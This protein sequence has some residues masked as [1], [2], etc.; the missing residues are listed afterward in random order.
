LSG[1]HRTRPG[2]WPGATSI[3]TSRAAARAA[4]CSTAEPDRARLEVAAVGAAQ[5][6]QQAALGQGGEGGVAAGADL[7]HDLAGALRDLA[8]VP[9]EDDADVGLDRR[10]RR[11]DLVRGLPQVAGLVGVRAVD[12]GGEL[13]QQAH[14]EVGTGGAQQAVAGEPARPQGGEGGG[15]A[16]R[17]DDQVEVAVGGELVE[18]VGGAAG[19]AV[20]TSERETRGVGIAVDHV[21]DL[22]SRH[23]QE[24]REDRRAALSRADERDDVSVLSHVVFSCRAPHGCGKWSRESDTVNGGR[25]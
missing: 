6:G 8:G 19:D 9:A 17:L 13:G 3:A 25:S 1:S 16:A 15:V 23:A 4:S 7:L 20:L 14:D 21:A 11:F 18:A 24:R 12:D 10:E 5:V 2:P 22:D